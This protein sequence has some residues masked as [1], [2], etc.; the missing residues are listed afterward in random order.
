MEFTER[1]HDGP[2]GHAYKFSLKDAIDDCE[3]YVVDWGEFT[4]YVRTDGQFRCQLIH[5][6]FRRIAAEYKLKC[7]YRKDFDEM[8][9]EHTQNPE[10][11]HMAK[12]MNV[13]DEEGDL[14]MDQG[15]WAAVCKSSL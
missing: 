13:I 4:S 12:R 8:F 7:I 9:A 2:F 6:A 5:K 15:Q 10:F 1:E 14:Y 3:E 11:F